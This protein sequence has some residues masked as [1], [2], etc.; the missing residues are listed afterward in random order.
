[1]KNKYFTIKKNVLTF[2]PDIGELDF[3][4]VPPSLHVVKIKSIILPSKVQNVDMLT[5]REFKDAES[6]FVNEN[7]PYFKTVDGVLFS[8][9]MKTLIYY[10]RNK[11]DIEYTVPDTV[12]TIAHAAFASCKNLT[13]INLPKGLELIDAC[14]FDG[15][16]N[17]K[18]MIIPEKVGVIE[19]YAFTDCNSL[20]N[21]KLPSNLTCISNYAFCN[22]NSLTK[23]DIP[24]SVIEVLSKA[25]INCVSLHTIKLGKNVT[26]L[27]SGL[28]TDCKNLKNLTLGNDIQTISPDAFM[29]CNLANLKIY[30]C[31]SPIVLEWA[32]E[33][34]VKCVNTD[35]KMKDFLNNI[36]DADINL[37]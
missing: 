28:F 26:S 20:E 9:D 23:I 25:F 1:M 6:V 15:C 18:N 37:N 31:N 7:N 12:T 10:P 2:N 36:I 30:N 19:A 11:K 35:T 4:N 34:H 33:N 22:C 16:T 17:V 24:D 13:K 21:I 27:S 14:A 32:K 3:V 8:K 5:I 29:G